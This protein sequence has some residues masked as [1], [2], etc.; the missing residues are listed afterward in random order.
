MFLDLDLQIV[1]KLL[2]ASLS[3]GI[4]GLQREIRDKPAERPAWG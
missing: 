1:E 2:L 4:A 3:G